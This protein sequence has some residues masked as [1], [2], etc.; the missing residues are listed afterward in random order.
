MNNIEESKI[1]IVKEEKGNNNTCIL[2]R[3]HDQQESREVLLRDILQGSMVT[4]TSVTNV[5]PNPRLYQAPRGIKSLL[6]YPL[7]SF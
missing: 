4:S 1:S 2:R 5:D 7:I 3:S 6:R